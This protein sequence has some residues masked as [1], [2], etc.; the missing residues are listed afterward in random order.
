MIEP[1]PF[2]SNRAHP[3]TSAD[4]PT[5]SKHDWCFN[6]Q[7]HV[8]AFPGQR[9]YSLGTVHQSAIRVT[10]V[11]WVPPAFCYLISACE[12][13]RSTAITTQTK[14]ANVTTALAACEYSHWIRNA[15]QFLG[16][17]VQLLVA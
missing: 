9:N 15:L 2:A 17:T 11:R 7:E 3:R 12:G 5:R 13:C 4:E 1:G 16:T 10:E 6:D 8:L 14:A